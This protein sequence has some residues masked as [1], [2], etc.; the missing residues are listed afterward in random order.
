MLVGSRMWMM[1]SHN[2]WTAMLPYRLEN[3]TVEGI[4]EFNFYSL[5]AKNRVL[6]FDVHFLLGV[7]RDRY[8]ICLPGNPVRLL[9]IINQHNL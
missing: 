8:V 6:S 1:M 5:L 2:P 3:S 9:I 7:M 4:K